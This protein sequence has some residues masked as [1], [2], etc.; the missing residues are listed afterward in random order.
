MCIKYVYKICEEKF[1][2]FLGVFMVKSES[3]IVRYRFFAAENKKNIRTIFVYIA[4]NY[5][6][7]Q[8]K[9][10]HIFHF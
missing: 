4:V 9:K 2:G 1:G 10:V 8:W 5:Q 7:K 3:Q 6:I